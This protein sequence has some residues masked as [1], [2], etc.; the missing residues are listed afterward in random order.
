MALSGQ[1]LELLELALVKLVSSDTLKLTHGSGL[2]TFAL[3]AGIDALGYQ[4]ERPPDR[5]TRSN[6]DASIAAPRAA[7]GRADCHDVGLDRSEVQGGA[8]LRRDGSG[9][10]RTGWV[11]EVEQ[12]RRLVRIEQLQEA[13]L[14]DGVVRNLPAAFAGATFHPPV[15]PAALLRWR[16]SGH[17]LAIKPL[18]R[19]R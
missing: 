3:L 5:S 15:A 11:V 17:G 18:D 2:Q 9:V 14:R 16:K 4:G 10:C 1:A 19:I 12:D 6:D 7:R 13:H 8:E